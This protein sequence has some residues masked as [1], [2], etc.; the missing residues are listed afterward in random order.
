MQFYLLSVKEVQ[1]YFFLK[2]LSFNRTE[3][4][5]FALLSLSPHLHLVKVRHRE[6]VCLCSALSI[7]EQ[8]AQEKH[9]CSSTIT[10]EMPGVQSRFSSGRTFENETKGIFK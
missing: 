6:V 3:H 7:H 2:C 8:R 9:P 5:K 1:I 4:I 10:D